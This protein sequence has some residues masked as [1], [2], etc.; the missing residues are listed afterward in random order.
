MDLNAV[1]ISEIT[2][3]SRNSVNKYMKAFRERITELSLLEYSNHDIDCFIRK[4][5]RNLELTSKDCITKQGS[6]KIFAIIQEEGKIY[7]YLFIKPLSIAMHQALRCGS[8][9]GDILSIQETNKHISLVDM[10]DVMYLPLHDHETKKENS[11]RLNRIDSFWGFCKN[12][13]LDKKNLS[14]KL[15]YYHLKECEY[16]YNY[17]TDLIYKNI[18]N[19]IRKESIKLS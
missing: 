17:N 2:H 14:Y 10:A 16:R 15:F 9:I 6:P 4:H 7:T 5:L 19:S 3:L 1:Q 8:T 18:L 13:L 11:G 12:R